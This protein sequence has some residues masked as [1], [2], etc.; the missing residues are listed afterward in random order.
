VARHAGRIARIAALLHLAQPPSD[1]PIS[2]ATMRDALRIGDYLLE[3]A[4][5]ALTVK[6]EG[7]RRVLRWL[8]DHP[9][10]VV[11]QRDLHR[12]P[13]NGRGSAD[14]AKA[15]AEELTSLG[16]LRPAAEESPSAGGRP[17]SPAYE[18]NP[19]LRPAPRAH[20]RT[21]VMEGPAARA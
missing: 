19:C 3:H 16:A 15:L 9:D 6:S 12:G 13:L 4:L 14:K 8:G 2:A 5:A 10:D 1:E 18:I 7:M 11:T 17:A 20:D 21:T